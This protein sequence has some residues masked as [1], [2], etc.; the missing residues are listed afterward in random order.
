MVYQVKTKY[1]SYNKMSKCRE[2]HSQP[3]E[4][5]NDCHCCVAV[6]GFKIPEKYKRKG[7]YR[8]TT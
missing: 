2:G 4:H 5:S 6:F 3:K 7:R 8:G 1:N